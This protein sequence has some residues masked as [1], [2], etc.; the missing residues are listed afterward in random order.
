[1]AEPHEH[2]PVEGVDPDDVPIDPEYRR[3]KIAL[4][5]LVLLAILVALVWFAVTHVQTSGGRGFLGTGG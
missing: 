2:E 5:C 4:G 1:M 3:T